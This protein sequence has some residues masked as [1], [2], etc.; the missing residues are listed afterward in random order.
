MDGCIDCVPSTFLSVSG[1]QRHADCQFASLQAD[2]FIQAIIDTRDFAGERFL[3]FATRKGTVKKTAFDAYNS[4]RRDG[5]IAIN[6]N[7]D[8]ELVRVI[9]TSGTDDI[10]M[11]A[12]S[13]MTIRFNEGDVRA[14]GAQRPVF[15]V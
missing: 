5:L 6:L 11:V 4:S 15:A 12:K 3:F 13:G 9:E 14:M 2:E 7:E 10:F 1:P 8:D